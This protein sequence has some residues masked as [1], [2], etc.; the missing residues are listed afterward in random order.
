MI[1]NSISSETLNRL[2]QPSAIRSNNPNNTLGQADFLLLLTTQLQNQDPTK[3]QNNEA[4]IAQ[5]ASFSSLE[6]SVAS[7]ATLEDISAK[8]DA[9]IAVQGGTNPTSPSS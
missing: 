8:L 7:N 6:A 5:M 1:D 9:L 2:N 4:M 3:P